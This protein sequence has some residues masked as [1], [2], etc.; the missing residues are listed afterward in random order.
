MDELHITEEGKNLLE[1]IRK[2][3]EIKFFPQFFNPRKNASPKDTTAIAWLSSSFF[4]A[5][6]VD[7]PHFDSSEGILSYNDI[8]QK[9]LMVY[10]KKPYGVHHIKNE[11]NIKNYRP[12]IIFYHAPTKCFWAGHLSTSYDN[13]VAPNRNPIVPLMLHNYVH[14]NVSMPDRCVYILSRTFPVSRN[15]VLF[16]ENNKSKF[17]NEKYDEFIRS[18]LTNNEFFT[19][20]AFTPFSQFYH[21]TSDN[22]ALVETSSAVF[23]FFLLNY[24]FSSSSI[25]KNFVNKHTTLSSLSLVQNIKEKYSDFLNILNNLYNDL[26][27][28][29]FLSNQ[30]TSQKID[31]KN[32]DYYIKNM[33][34]FEEQ[35][36]SLKETAEKI[37]LDSQKII[38]F[39]T[40]LG[41]S[42]ISDFDFNLGFA[43][44]FCNTSILNSPNPS[45]EN[46][47]KTFTLDE[48]LLDKRLDS[49]MKKPLE[50]KNS[51]SQAKTPEGAASPTREKQVDDPTEVFVKYV[52]ANKLSKTLNAYL[53]VYPRYQAII[54]N[55][56]DGITL[57]SST[58]PED[59]N[60]T[61]MLVDDEHLVLSRKE[62]ENSNECLIRNFNEIKDLID[63]NVDIEVVKILI[64]IINDNTQKQIIDEKHLS[65]INNLLNN[66]TQFN[67]YIT[68]L[69]NQI[70][71]FEEISYD[72]STIFKFISQFNELKKK[73]EELQSK[74]KENISALV[75]LF[76]EIKSHLDDILLEEQSTLQRFLT[77][78]KDISILKNMDS[79][80]FKV[81]QYAEKQKNISHLIMLLKETIDQN[82][83][84]KEQHKKYLNYSDDELKEQINLPSKF[85]SSF[86]E[87]IKLW[88]ILLNLSM[89]SKIQIKEN[90]PLEQIIEDIT[91]HIQS[92]NYALLT[93]INFGEIITEFSFN[94]E[95]SLSACESSY[96]PYMR[97][98]LGSYVEKA[99]SPSGNIEAIKNLLAASSKNYFSVLGNNYD[100]THNFMDL[101][102]DQK[103]KKLINFL[104]K[105]ALSIMDDKKTSKFVYQYI[106]SQKLDED[107][108]L[109][110]TYLA[111]CY[112]YIIIEE[113][114]TFQKVPN[115][116]QYYKRF[117]SF[118]THLIKN[119]FKMN[120][121]SNCELED[122]INKND[123]SYDKVFN[124]IYH[125]NLIF[126]CAEDLSNFL[127]R[128]YSSEKYKKIIREEI[129][130]ILNGTSSESK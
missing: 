70:Y 97:E 91:T 114:P 64:D 121:I 86:D 79:I 89:K 100:P 43:N 90:Q 107:T 63:K 27:N 31:Y 123:L 116:T 1:Q 125:I 17:D 92:E 94:F 103:I 11:N 102:N 85:Q 126:T 44:E 118:L 5:Q 58:L 73:I 46:V 117:L 72:T 24:L 101:K 77:L 30:L 105:S 3:K 20:M 51:L 13:S 60:F 35:K 62:N 48:A 16:S 28:Y 69:K 106:K 78:D 87:E 83:F 112:P 119:H 122:L 39:L 7:N 115:H 42:N 40:S 74:V 22:S 129:E 10:T 12:H 57:F 23:G 130:T 4:T 34:F 15:M 52:K 56:N 108:S 66:R 76:P 95:G 14:S 41:I 128:L 9:Y 25:I 75:N 99:R 67:A 68:N 113:D 120:N 93:V 80:F 124:L 18:N 127:T 37:G 111:K 45:F 29:F 49:L 38:E 59:I 98:A 53:K 55:L 33:T 84:L 110:I 61:Q 36:K 8:F 47:I 19:K 96:V 32:N 21:S 6:G 26:K 71:L 2:T 104:T 81:T 82:A 88:K 54:Q 109:A 50:E 65:I